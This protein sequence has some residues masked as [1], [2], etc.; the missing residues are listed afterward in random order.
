MWFILYFC[1][2][3][4]QQS[5]TRYFF[6]FKVLNC[7]YLSIVYLNCRAGNVFWGIFFLCQFFLQSHEK[8]HRLWTKNLCLARGLLALQIKIPLGINF[9]GPWE[10]GKWFDFFFLATLTSPP[11]HPSPPC[12]SKIVYGAQC[13]GTATIPGRG[14]MV[15]QQAPTRRSGTRRYDIRHAAI[16]PPATQISCHRHLMAPSHAAITSYCYH[17]SVPPATLCHPGIMPLL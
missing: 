5:I 13:V 11:G 8:S 9:L 16:R 17:D 3:C 6:T 14:Q 12:F 1:E 10:G 15:L 7:S 4:G 2:N